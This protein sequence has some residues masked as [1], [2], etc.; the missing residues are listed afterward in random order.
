[1][2][3]IHVAADWADIFD[4]PTKQEKTYLQNL[5]HTVSRK[6]VIQPG[7]RSKTLGTGVSLNL[8]LNILGNIE[9][10]ARTRPVKNGR[11]VT[12]FH[13]HRQV[14]QQLFMIDYHLHSA[15]NMRCEQSRTRMWDWHVMVP[16][17]DLV[18]YTNCVAYS[19]YR[20][21]WYW[22]LFIMPKLFYCICL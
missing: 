8:P 17:W 6:H 3:Y 5:L 1:M 11:M 22:V 4:T 12:L 10:L 13:G 9:I 18:P 14:V 20:E 16:P 7:N 19:A 21:L 15:A 2:V